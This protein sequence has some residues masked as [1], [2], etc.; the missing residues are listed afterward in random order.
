[1]I[2]LCASEVFL[3][4]KWSH[5]FQIGCHCVAPCGAKLVWQTLS[6]CCSNY[7][8]DKIIST[9][10]PLNSLNSFVFL[11]VLQFISLFSSIF[12]STLSHYKII[13][14]YF[15]ICLTFSCISLSW[16]FLYYFWDQLGWSNYPGK[17][18]DMTRQLSFISRENNFDH[19]LHF[20]KQT[21]T[22]VS[23]QT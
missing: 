13:S 22:K 10:I 12:Y 3:F 7:F 8:V 1:M 20:L 19:T 14:V 16:L 5:H 4:I 15:S 6:F 18:P 21:Q 17:H 9:L 11:S 2:I 23:K